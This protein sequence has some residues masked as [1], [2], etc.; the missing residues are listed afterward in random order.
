MPTHPSIA[1]P[2]RGVVLLAIVVLLAAASFGALVHVARAADNTHVACVYHGFVAGASDTDGSFFS[3]ISP[4]CSSSW[5]QCSIYSYSTLR[6]YQTVYDTT[7]T[8]SSWSRDY[9]DYTECASAAGVSNPAA[10][11]DHQHGA[12]C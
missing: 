6:G 3:R 1:R 11:G 10:F 5:R 2:Q 12:I 7:S 4:G 8:C 9:G